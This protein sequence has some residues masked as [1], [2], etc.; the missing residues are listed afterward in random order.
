V[1]TCHGC[2]VALPAA[3]AAACNERGLPLSS[4]IWCSRGLGALDGHPSSCTRH[5]SMRLREHLQLTVLWH[6]WVRN[7]SLPW[8][9]TTM[10]ANLLVQCCCCVDHLSSHC[11]RNYRCWTT[12]HQPLHAKNYSS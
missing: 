12:S 5:A 11:Q 9:H 10:Q 1:A 2:C 4:T 7:L 8:V 3:G 6:Q